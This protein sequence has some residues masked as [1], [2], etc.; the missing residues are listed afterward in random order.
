MT[1][2]LSTLTYTTAAQTDDA[3]LNNIQSVVRQISELTVRYQNAR[4]GL[5]GASPGQVDHQASP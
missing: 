4:A 3:A 1:M 2:S 5:T